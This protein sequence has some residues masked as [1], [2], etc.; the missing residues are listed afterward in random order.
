VSGVV[1]LFESD[2]GEPLA[3]VEPDVINSHAMLLAHELST[4]AGDLE[5]TEAV[6]NKYLAHLGDEAFMN[7]CCRALGTLT[8]ILA[9]V[10]T[11]TDEEGISAR[12]GLALAFQDA[13][14]LSK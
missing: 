6:L 10:L 4:V 3:V 7:C 11:L 9:A 2:L 14:G 8:G 5:A 1:H 13:L 12:H